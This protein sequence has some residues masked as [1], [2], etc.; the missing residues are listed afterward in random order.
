[1]HEI[2]TEEG[3]N[4]PLSY[5]DVIRTWSLSGRSSVRPSHLQTHLRKRVFPR[6]LLSL[7]RLAQLGRLPLPSSRERLPK[8]QHII[9]A[10]ATAG[11]VCIA[12]NFR[13]SSRHTKNH[14]GPRDD[15]CMWL[16]EVSSCLPRKN[17]IKLTKSIHSHGPSKKPETQLA[18]I[19]KTTN[20]SKDWT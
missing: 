12:I 6:R 17:R 18:T 1:M 16:G 3:V 15:D 10:S 13:P 2:A 7:R 9:R 5:G 11:R 20:Q 14:T 4:I 19:C 8:I